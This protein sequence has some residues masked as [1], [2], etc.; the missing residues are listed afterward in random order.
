MKMSFDPGLRQGQVIARAQQKIGTS[1]EFLA[2]A[3]EKAKEHITISLGG[4]SWWLT[5]INLLSI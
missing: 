4:G 5:W 2:R 3:C 1:E